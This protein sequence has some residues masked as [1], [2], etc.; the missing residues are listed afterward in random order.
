[1]VDLG[2]ASS[3]GILAGS[4]ITSNGNTSID[5]DIGIWPDSASSITGFPPGFYTGTIHAGNSVAQQAQSD[6][7]ATYN[8]LAGL[9]MTHDLTGVDL[10]GMTL[11]EGIYSFSSS[12]QLTGGL[13]LDAQ[14]N[15]NA[16]FIFQIGTTLTTAGDSAIMMLNAPTE[17][18]GI[19][20]QVGSSATLGIGT[21]F[22]GSILADQS[23]TLNGGSL[24]GRAIALNG[25][26]TIAEQQTIIVP[27]PATMAM[28][29]F[30]A[31]FMSR[32]LRKTR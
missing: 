15:P 13:T 17:F 18:A 25:A 11:T 29:I 31:G 21:D 26:V 12:A 4:A 6:A 30:G 14:N 23:I 5:G 7:V 16:V 32:K 2:S 9:A 3:F 10:G 22:M 27:E 28:L 19:Y 8:G 20:W 24:L 1:M